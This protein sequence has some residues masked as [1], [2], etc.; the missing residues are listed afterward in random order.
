MNRETNTT[1]DKSKGDAKLKNVQ[2]SRAGCIE[3]DKEK[4]GASPQYIRPLFSGRNKENGRNRRP[5][6]SCHYA[7][8]E[9]TP[10]LPEDIDL[11]PGRTERSET[12]QLH[13]GESLLFNR[14]N[15]PFLAVRKY[16]RDHNLPHTSK[17]YS[18]GKTVHGNTYRLA[19]H[20]YY[21]RTDRRLRDAVDGLLLLKRLSRM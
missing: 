5:L 3:P 6:P 12:K 19:E 13:K 9:P 16:M 7:W 2:F 18:S 20:Q 10:L 11:K 21:Y 4:V 14:S 8:P 15:E 1:S 17:T